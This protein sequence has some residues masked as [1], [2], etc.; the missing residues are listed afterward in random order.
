MGVS[1]KVSRTGTRFRPKPLLQ[2]EVNAIDD[3]SENSKES[4]RKLQVKLR[5]L[6]QSFD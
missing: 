6:I 4:S 1:F 3:V 2:P 5:V